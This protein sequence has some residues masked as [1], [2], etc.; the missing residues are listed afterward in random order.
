M[1]FSEYNDILLKLNKQS[2]IKKLA[3]T[4]DYDEEL[5]LVIY[6][7]KIVQNA[8]KRYYKIKHLAPKY[9]K[10]WL[11]GESLLAISKKLKFPPVLT[12]LLILKEDGISRKMFRKYLNDL[13]LVKDQRLRK[14]LEEVI[15]NDII[16]SPEGNDIQAKRGQIGE[17]RINQWLTDHNIEFQSEKELTPEYE[18]TPDFLLKFPLN[19]RGIDIHWI[20]SKATFGN[21]SE[22][23]KN[24]KNQLAPYHELFGPGMVIYWYGFISPPPLVKGILIENGEFFKGWKE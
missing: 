23:K 18:K 16:Y 14:E 19:V 2:D 17:E 20:E 12:A 9:R 4:T 7:Q 11:K 24:I 10:T 22:I 15:A 3:K 8:T 21:K 6:S 13:T 5:L 1:K